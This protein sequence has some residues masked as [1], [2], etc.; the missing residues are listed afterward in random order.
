MQ[1]VQ[2]QWTKKTALSKKYFVL[3]TEGTGCFAIIH[4]LKF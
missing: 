4:L 1:I 2:S 3:L